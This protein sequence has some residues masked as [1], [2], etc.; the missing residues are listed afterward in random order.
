MSWFHSSTAAVNA[1][2]YASSVE[3]V[4]EA[5]ALRRYGTHLIAAGRLCDAQATN[6]VL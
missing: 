4:L 2:N 1:R 6:L 5:S 3:I